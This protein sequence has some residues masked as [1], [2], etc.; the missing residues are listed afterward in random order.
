MRRFD[1]RVLDLENEIQVVS[2][3]TALGVDPAGIKRMAG[4]AQHL[5]VLIE[6][7]PCGA[8]NIIK[9]EMLA[10][11]ADAAVARGSVTCSRPL[12]DVLLMGSKKQL[13]SLVQRLPYQPFGLA[14]VAQQLH[15]LLIHYSTY[16]TYLAGRDC[17]LEFDR[18]K[19]M[20]IINVTP[21]SFYDG[22]VSCSVEDAL[23]QAELQVVAGADLLDIGGESTRP[24]SLSVSAQSECDRVV[25][26]IE[27]IRN[28]FAIPISIDT[29]KASVAQAAMACGANFI[30]DIS[31]LTFDSNM[32]Q[33]VAQ[34]GAG[35]FVMHTRGRPDVMQQDV[36]YQDLVAEVILGLRSSINLAIE[37]GVSTDKISIDP[38]ICFGKSVDGNLEILKRLSELRVLGYPVLLGTS[39]KSFIGSILNQP[40]PEQRLNGSLATVSVAVARGVQLFRVHDV[41]ATR[42]V[43]D[44]AW[45]MTARC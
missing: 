3:M 6:A 20:G 26:I 29:T 42:H 41:E 25:P 2:A 36:Q 17:R 39:R 13:F 4:K 35:L 37:A 32:A 31:G 15:S 30:N 11:G 23:R 5:N 44:M 19:I 16:P 40:Q 24:G 45:A 27:A 43:A 21:D 14:T 10:I 12:T 18:P 34:S 8:A 28:R 38:G 22:G 9:Q 33:V 1:L 7:V